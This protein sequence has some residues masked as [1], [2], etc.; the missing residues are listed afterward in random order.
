MRGVPRDRRAIAA[1][2]S[3]SV[4]ISKIRAERR[5]NFGE[6]YRIVELK[7]LHNAKAIAQRRSQQSGPGG[8]AYQRKRWQI[9]F[10]RARGRPSPIMM[11]S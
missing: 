7:A 9:Q 8:R 3:S 2:P 10:Y 1:A 11:S 4:E 5:H 6:L